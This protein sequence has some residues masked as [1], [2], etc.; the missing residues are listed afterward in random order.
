MS[1]RSPEKIVE[2]E[3]ESRAPR[4][5]LHRSYGYRG[6]GSGFGRGTDFNGG[7]VHWG[8]GFGGVGVAGGYAGNTLPQAALVEGEASDRGPYFGVAPVVYSR[9]EESIR[10]N[11]GE[12][13]NR[14]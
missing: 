9:P 1:R 8:S 12:E 3:S 2:N 11:I 13:L 4:P 6:Y 5:E 14:R 7:M 10:E